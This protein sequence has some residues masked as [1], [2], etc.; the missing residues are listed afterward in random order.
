MIEAI[1]KRLG[2]QLGAEG[3]DALVILENYKTGKIRRIWGRNIITAAGD[4]W[5]GQKAC[6]Q[7]PTYNFRNCYLA[8]S[9]ITPAKSNTY[10]SFGS[11]VPTNAP[12]ESGYPKTEDADTDNSGSGVDI[13]SWKYVF[14]TA[15]GAFANITHSFIAATNAAAGSLILNAYAWAA[16]WS[17]DADTSAKVFAN[18]QMNGT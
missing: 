16:S 11:I 4:A 6:G 12:P 15:H 10:S 2:K 17:K 7:T 8:G 9:G 14:G 13:V 18:H 5:Y 1:L 3:H